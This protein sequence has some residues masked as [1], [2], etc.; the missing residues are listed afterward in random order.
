MNAESFLND[1]WKC[2]SKAGAAEQL[3]ASEKLSFL[4]SHS[5]ICIIGV[6]GVLIE[7]GK[8][9]PRSAAVAVL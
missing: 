2:R 9:L 8:T 1:L 3:K 7:K 5:V 6:V 4:L